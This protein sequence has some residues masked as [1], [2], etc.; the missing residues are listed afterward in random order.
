VAQTRHLST[1][2]VNK[3]A[4]PHKW[5]LRHAVAVACSSPTNPEDLDRDLKTAVANH[6]GTVA[7]LVHQSRLHED[8]RLPPLAGG[9]PPIP[10]RN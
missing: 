6:L 7:Q 10:Q 4:D 2:L 5:F 1:Q 9:Q 3:L 8:R